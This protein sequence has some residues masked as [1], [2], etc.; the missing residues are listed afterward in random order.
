M[1]RRT[2]DRIN[3]MARPEALAAFKACCGSTKYAEVSRTSLCASS[4]A[5]KLGCGGFH[6]DLLP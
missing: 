4:R 5:N 2:M 6:V 3:G 1:S